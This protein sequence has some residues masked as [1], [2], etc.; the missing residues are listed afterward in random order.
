MRFRSLPKKP[1][2]IYWFLTAIVC[3][4][5]FRIPEKN[6]VELIIVPDKP[7]LLKPSTER[8][9]I[10]FRVSSASTFIHQNVVKQHP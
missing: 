2:S 7:T 10:I 5:F 6:S 9:L 1:A 4:R 8:D 3:L